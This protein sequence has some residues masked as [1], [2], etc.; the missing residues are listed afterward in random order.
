MA[1]SV[2]AVDDAIG[3]V[4][5]GSDG[6]RFW[7]LL[8]GYGRAGLPAGLPG[9]LDGIRLGHGRAHL[10]RSVVEGLCLELGRYLKLLERGGLGVRGLTLSGAAARSSVTPQI[11]ADVTGLA[12]EVT[13]QTD[14]SARGAA[15][16][17]R[18]MLEP[19]RSLMQLSTDLAPPA[20]R[21]QPGPHAGTYQS[22]LR[23]YLAS[24]PAKPT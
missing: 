10:L 23:E 9:R 7:P 20:R 8:V 24:L 22:M 3:T 12:V 17:A 1:S 6:L 16:L 21:V 2:E 4:V 11:V 19:G 18:A 14:S 15:L 13:T 5:P